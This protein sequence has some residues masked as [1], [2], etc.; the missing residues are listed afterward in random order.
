MGEGEIP[1]I[2]RIAAGPKTSSS[3]SLLTSCPYCR[4]SR[5]LA[6]M[7]AYFDLQVIVNTPDIATRYPNLVTLPRFLCISGSRDT[8]KRLPIRTHLQGTANN[9]G[10]DLIQAG[11]S[12]SEIS[13][14]IVIS[15]AAPSMAETLQY[16]VS[17]SSIA[18]ATA[19][20]STPRPRMW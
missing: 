9:P 1:R 18:W 17:E 2:G 4:H 15:A 16:L 8:M 3:K 19:R 7:R 13:W 5:S 12:C 10:F 14:R 6:Q 20:G 11:Y